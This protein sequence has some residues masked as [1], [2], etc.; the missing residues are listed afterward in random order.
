MLN[1]WDYKKNACIYCASKVIHGDPSFSVLQPVTAISS[2]PQILLRQHGECPTI[3][4]SSLSSLQLQL[5]YF[6][7]PSSVAFTIMQAIGQAL[8]T[9]RTP[10]RQVAME[11]RCRTHRLRVA[12]CLDE[13]VGELLRQER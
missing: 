10:S 2:H 3:V 9:R 4:V 5:N 8:S 6:P 13:C 12:V 1:V 7:L 11:G